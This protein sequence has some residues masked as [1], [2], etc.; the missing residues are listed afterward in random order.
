MPRQ[1]SR[2]DG[3]REPDYRFPLLL[4]GTLAL[5]GESTTD[6][7]ESPALPAV[8]GSDPAPREVSHQLTSEGDGRVRDIGGRYVG[9]SELAVQFRDGDIAG[10]YPD[11]RS[12]DLGT[13]VPTMVA[14][15][16]LLGGGS[17]YTLYSPLYGYERLGPG[18]S[19]DGH[20]IGLA[21]GIRRN[22]PER[23]S[24]RR[25]LRMVPP[26]G[27]GAEG[28]EVQRRAPAYFRPDGP[29]RVTTVIGP[30]TVWLAG[31]F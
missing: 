29:L 23:A 5:A 7:P 4:V 20:G 12:G 19:W 27:A 10:A 22:C 6:V 30:G 24:P 15:G 21:T 9:V 14:G 3:P 18:C 28:V 8:F 26:E 25:R 2:N 1:E 17:L 13:L 11:A 31:T 16:L